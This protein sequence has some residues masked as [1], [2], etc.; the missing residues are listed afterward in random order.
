MLC[1]RDNFM[2]YCILFLSTLLIFAGAVFSSPTFAASSAGELVV[3]AQHYIFGPN[4]EIPR[5][6]KQTNGPFA[7]M[8]F[9]EYAQ[10]LHLGII[11]YD[12]MGDP[13]DGKW[14]I[15]ERFWHD[16]DWGA[17]ITSLYWS[18]DG[19]SL[20]VATDR[21]YGDGGIFRLDLYEKKFEKIYPKTKADYHAITRTEIVSVNQDKRRM[22]IRAFLDDLQ[23][24]FEIIY[25]PVK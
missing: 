16:R 25:V 8:L 24:K 1:I 15:S 11:Y 7:A 9:Q 17:A 10:G 4:Q 20:Y 18:S 23:S 21:V 5:I 6:V 3:T 19:K 13:M 2:R 12:Q 14:W 22:K